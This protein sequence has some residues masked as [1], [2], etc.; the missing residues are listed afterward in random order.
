MA[1]FYFYKPYGTLSQFINNGKRKARHTLIGDFGNFPD[2]TMAIGRLDRDSEGL[3]LLTTDGLFSQ[4]MR[5]KTI[6]K[7]YWVQVD[8][9]PSEDELQ[10]LRT[11]VTLSH[12]GASYHTRPAKVSTL[13]TPTLPPRGK[14]IRSERHGQT[15]WLQII[16]TE[17]KFRQVRK[18]TAKIGYP[19]LRL[20]RVRVGPYLLDNL[21]P[22]ESKPLQRLS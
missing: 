1:D 6:E 4:E 2:G 11:G 20:V 10:K 14:P 5:S 17:G 9:T 12:K 7:E 15:C 21:Q 19:T 22:G 3:L 8:G 16:L 18:M 13:L